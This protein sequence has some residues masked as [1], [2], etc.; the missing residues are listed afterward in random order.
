MQSQHGKLIIIGASGHGRVVLDCARCAGL[1]PIGFVDR[2]FEPGDVVGGVPVLA[3][4]PEECDE[5]RVGGHLWFIAVG[6]NRAREGLAE[7]VASLTARPATSVV[8]PHSVISAAAT[9]G[10]GVFI[11]PGAIL[12]TDVRVG[13]GVIVN[14]AAT[15]DH[16]GVVE[17]FAQISPG[18]RLAGNV[19][20]GARVFLGTGAVVIPGIAIGAD[21]VVGAGAVVVEDVAA[22]VTAIGNPARPR[23]GD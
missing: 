15:I 14:T 12:N 13:P 11:G 3:R 4:E 19:T 21:A 5:L 2:A 9:F 18:C 22:S 6:D 20:V 17:R 16:D 1:L 8:H 7:R 23:L 10:D